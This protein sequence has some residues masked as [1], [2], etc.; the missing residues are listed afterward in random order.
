VSTSHRIL[1]GPEVSRRRRVLR[2][3]LPW[4]I[5]AALAVVA[6]SCGLRQTGGEEMQVRSCHGDALANASLMSL[7]TS[8]QVS[9]SAAH[10]LTSV[11]PISDITCA[12][13]VRPAWQTDVT[14]F[15]AGNPWTELFEKHLHN[16][17]VYPV[18]GRSHYERRPNDLVACRVEFVSMASRDGEYQ[19]ISIGTVAPSSSMR[20]CS[21]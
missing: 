20:G 17:E 5:S 13:K 8:N 7:L 6:F 18:G 11:V 10:F 4:S 21:E 2:T 14:D 9:L 16:V 1:R 19:N 3:W 15:K 12:L